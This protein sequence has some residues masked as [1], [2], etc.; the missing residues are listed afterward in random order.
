MLFRTAQHFLFLVIDVALSERLNHAVPDYRLAEHL[1]TI[2][3][4]PFIDVAQSARLTH[5]VPHDSVFPNTIIRCI[6]HQGQAP[7]TCCIT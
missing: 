4:F 5:A 1:C 2:Y 3:I 7:V 6:F